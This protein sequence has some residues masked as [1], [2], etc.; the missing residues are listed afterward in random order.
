MQNVRLQT[1]ALFYYYFTLVSPVIDKS[2]DIIVVGDPE[3]LKVTCNI[4]RSNP[5]PKIT[6]EYQPSGCQNQNLDCKPVEA[7]WINGEEKDITSSSNTS[8]FKVP[9]SSV[10]KFFVRCTARHNFGSDRHQVFAIIDK[11]GNTFWPCSCCCWWCFRC[12]DGLLVT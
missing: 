11:R 5:V 12:L 4:R 1:L 7:N 6:W 9:S 3:K 2:K 8:T 10:K